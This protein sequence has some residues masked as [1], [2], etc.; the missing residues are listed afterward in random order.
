MIISWKKWLATESLNSVI[1]FGLEVGIFLSYMVN[2]ENNLFFP[3][4]FPEFFWCYYVTQLFF[5]FLFKN[6]SNM[7]LL[8]L[9][10]ILFA[11]DLPYL[12][13]RAYYLL[14]FKCSTNVLKLLSLQFCTN[15][16]FQGL[17]P[18]HHTK[19]AKLFQR[20]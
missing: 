14:S 3:A 20:F 5:F 18:L 10:V 13:L 4:L 7:C 6:P 8:L 19:L 17:H 15:Q 11:W 12:I 16:R 1:S 2:F 9:I